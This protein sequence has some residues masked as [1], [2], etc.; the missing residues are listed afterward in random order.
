[1]TELE[2]DAILARLVPEYESAK[3]QSI[4][5]RNQ[6][7]LVSVGRNIDRKAVIDARDRWQEL[8]DN[9]AA[10]LQRIEQLAI[11]SEA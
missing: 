6:L 3:L 2:V 1:M 10:I 11:L 9:C 7:L 8:E 4:E 5:A